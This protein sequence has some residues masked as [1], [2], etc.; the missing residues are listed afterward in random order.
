MPPREDGASPKSFTWITGNPRSKKNIT[1]I[2]RHAGQNSGVKA[3][4]GNRVFSSTSPNPAQESALKP[5]RAVYPS[6]RTDETDRD[7][8][9]SS[10]EPPSGSSHSRYSSHVVEYATAAL[11]TTHDQVNS[12]QHAYPST[13]SSEVPPSTGEE[14]TPPRKVAIW[15][16]VNHSAEEEEQHR[17]EVLASTPREDTEDDRQDY[18]SG[19]TMRPELKQALTEARAHSPKHSHRS[20]PS[21]TSFAL[22]ANVSKRRKAAAGAAALSHVSWRLGMTASPRPLSLSEEDS[23]IA[24]ILHQTGAYWQGQFESSWSVHLREK[25]STY[26]DKISGME[27]FAGSITTAGGLMELGRVDSASSMLSRTL[28]MLW[29]LLTAQHP[30][31]YWLLADLSLSAS[32]DTALGRLRSQVKRV[33]ASASLKTLGDSHPLTKILFMRLPNMA[34][35]QRAHLREVIQRK[36]HE[37]HETLFESDS[38]QTTGQYYYLARVLGQIGRFEASREVLSQVVNTWEDTYGQNH[39]MP[40]TGL[41][42]LTR[43]QLSLNDT[44]AE[45]ESLLSEALRRTLTLEKASTDP[46]PTSPSQKLGPKAAAL[47]LARM[48]CLRTLGKLHVM[49]GNLET[50][51]MQYTAAVSIGVGELGLH[52]PAVQLAL[53]DLNAVSEILRARGERDDSVRQ[54]WLQRTPVEVGIRWVPGSDDGR[55]Q[56]ERERD[57]KLVVEQLGLIDERTDES[58]AGM[59]R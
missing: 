8:L 11:P 6:P 3:E 47:T 46:T 55:S 56:E 40:I 36:I 27:S 26:F 57:R 52:I 45:T 30:Q 23:H 48:G 29:S 20:S 41:L 31:T 32:P 10:A 22:Q 35:S 24:Q 4:N 38:Y 19:S 1:Q 50:A 28:P 54:E 44:S 9:G 42:E 59:G 7:S 49:R 53:A 37:L 5:L 14:T 34:E 43:V 33:V 15:D 51:M 18:F 13:P 39:I 21:P 58:E 12:F 17:L 2:R 16:L 25:G